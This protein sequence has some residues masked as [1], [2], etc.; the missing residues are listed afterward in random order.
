MLQKHCQSTK[1]FKRVKRS[2]NPVFQGLN[3]KEQSRLL[4]HENHKHEKL[5]SIIKMQK[6]FLNTK[7]TLLKIPI[8]RK[9]F[10]TQCQRRDKTFE[11]N[12]Q[13]TL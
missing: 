10:F 2:I 1:S 9:V 5:Y 13:E 3:L 4:D 11:R 7:S 8:Y 6:H 12:K